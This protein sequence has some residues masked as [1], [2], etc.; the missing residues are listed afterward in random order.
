MSGGGMN[1]LPLLLAAPFAGACVCAVS[2]KRFAALVRT[3]ASLAVFW[4]SSARRRAFASAAPSPGRRRGSPST[5][6]R[7]SCSSRWA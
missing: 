1:I 4:L 6:S 3:A 2:G 7:P 5:A